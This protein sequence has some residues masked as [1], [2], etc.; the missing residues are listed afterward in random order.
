MTRIISLGCDV[1]NVRNRYTR[2]HE[3]VFGVSV[4]RVVDLMK[5][6][7]CSVCRTCAGELDDLEK[8]LCAIQAEIEAIPPE[9][10]P[11]RG[12][13]PLRATLLRYIKV[14]LRAMKSLEGICRRLGEEG[15]RYRESVNG[16]RSR[17]R[18]DKVDY[19]YLI[20]ELENLGTKLNRL[21]SSY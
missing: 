5:G 12:A 2:I 15:E 3:T 20:V 18:Q 21:F 19:E 7:E 13:E 6:R 4:K 8:E 11:P 17:F 10:R 1:V 9:E 14:L 16:E